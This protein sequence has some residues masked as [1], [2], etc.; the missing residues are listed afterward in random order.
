MWGCAIGPYSGGCRGKRKHV[1]THYIVQAYS[2]MMERR[3]RELRWDD[4]DKLHVAFL[5]PFKS[6]SIAPDEN[7]KTT[8]VEIES[9]VLYII[10]NGCLRRRKVKRRLAAKQV[11]SRGKIPLSMKKL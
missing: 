5:Q 3:L 10:I 7:L 2:M 11:R 6:G 4:N 8:K 1:T 9:T